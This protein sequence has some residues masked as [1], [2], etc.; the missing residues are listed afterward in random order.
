MNCHYAESSEP[1]AESAEQGGKSSIATVQQEPCETSFFDGTQF[2]M[3]SSY[4]QEMACAMMESPMIAMRK[5]LE[6]KGLTHQG[7]RP[8]LIVRICSHYDIDHVLGGNE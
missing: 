5:H 3:L 7:T 1:C 8:F 2:S 6:L 4:A